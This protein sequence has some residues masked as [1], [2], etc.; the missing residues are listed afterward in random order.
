MKNRCVGV[1]VGGSCNLLPV[2]GP[3]FAP[4]SRLAPAIYFWLGVA[5][6][7]VE[8]SRTTL[9]TKRDRIHIFRQHVL[10][11]RLGLVVGGRAN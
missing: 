4:L 9:S 8:E 5:L 11:D 1:C 2:V 3:L 10:L 6:S 7:A